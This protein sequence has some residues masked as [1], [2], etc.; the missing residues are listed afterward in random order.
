MYVYIYIYMYVYTYIFIYIY[1][2]IYMCIYT[3]LY[4]YIYIFICVYIHIY[5]Y[6]YIYIIICCE[7]IC[8]HLQ[9]KISWY[10]TPNHQLSSHISMPQQSENDH[11]SSIHPICWCFNNMKPAISSIKKPDG[12]GPTFEA[13]TQD[14]WFESM[15][16]ING[17]LMFSINHIIYHIISYHIIS[18][19]QGI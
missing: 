18:Y 1:I 7:H 5:I 12:N 16:S 10:S 15:F 17:Y 2:Y 4:M 11:V 8:P 14:V 9:Q 13:W 6:T 19:L 3:Y